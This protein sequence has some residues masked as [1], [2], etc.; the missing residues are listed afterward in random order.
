[1]QSFYLYGYT[2]YKKV[3]IP[4]RER[5]HAS[6]RMSK[7]YSSSERAT[8]TSGNKPGPQHSLLEC[9]QCH[10]CKL[11][12]NIHIRRIQNVWWQTNY[13]HKHRKANTPSVAK[14]KRKNVVR[15]LPN[16]YHLPQES[17]TN[18]NNNRAPTIRKDA[19]INIINDDPN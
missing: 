18:N 12:H 15:I 10:R 7:K 3:Y 16:S 2:F 17:S 19:W 5:V 14:P 1:M 9:K 4:L 6:F 11:H 8:N 13:N